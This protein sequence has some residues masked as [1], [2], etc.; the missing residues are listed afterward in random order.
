MGD[1][2]VHFGD[3]GIFDIPREFQTKCDSYNIKYF[4]DS[5]K[6]LEYAKNNEKDICIECLRRVSEE[7]RNLSQELA[8]QY[9]EI[10]YKYGNWLDK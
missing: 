6:F 2:K 1:C 9:A 10:Q 7:I 3:S 8:I 5:V 4:T